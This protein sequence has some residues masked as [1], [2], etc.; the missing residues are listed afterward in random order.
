V[1]NWYSVCQ[2][3]RLKD[4]HISLVAGILKAQR[5]ELAE[6]G[7][8]TLAALGQLPIPLE[9][10]PTHGSAVALERV[11]EQARLQLEARTSG[12]PTYEL[13][14]IEEGCGLA[15]LPPASPL[16]VFLDLEGDRVL[17]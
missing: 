10:K 13:L 16:D 3:R 9:R 17:S 5:R 15:A 14:P 11:R 8:T 2:D 4:D 1:C 7:V 6:W 12:K